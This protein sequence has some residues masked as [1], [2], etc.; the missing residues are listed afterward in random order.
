MHA[1]YSNEVEYFRIILSQFIE[2]RLMF[3]VCIFTV[4]R[5]RWLYTCEAITSNRVLEISVSSHGVLPPNDGD[6][7]DDVWLCEGI[8]THG[9][10]S[11]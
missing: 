4:S 6:D 11:S 10:L 2:S 5:S 3:T 9:Y 1:A 7:D 8:L